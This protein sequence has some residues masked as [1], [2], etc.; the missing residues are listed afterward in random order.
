LKSRLKLTG[1]WLRVFL[2][3]CSIFLRASFADLLESEDALC[4]DIRQ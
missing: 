2:A 4:C 3:N 1:P